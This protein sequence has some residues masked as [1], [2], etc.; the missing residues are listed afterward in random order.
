MPAKVQPKL[1]GSQL[2]SASEN[3]PA[4]SLSIRPANWCFANQNL[5]F[6]FCIFGM[7]AKPFPCNFAYSGHFT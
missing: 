3:D 1:A 4:F 7:A 5:H 2:I 6:A